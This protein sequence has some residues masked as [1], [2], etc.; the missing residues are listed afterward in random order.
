MAYADYEF[1]TETYKGNMKQ[2]DF[3]RLSERASDIIN[4]RTGF[5][6]GRCGFN[7]IREELAERVKKACCS[8]SE[9]LYINEKGGAKQSEKVGDYSV[10]Y[11]AGA[12]TN[13][14]RID[15]AL[16]TY[17]PDIVKTAGWI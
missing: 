11:A 2:T 12:L 4:S 16:L 15:N 5:L 8:V 3:C 9:A 14:Q 6:I 7:N 1:Y 17:I 10:T 13:E